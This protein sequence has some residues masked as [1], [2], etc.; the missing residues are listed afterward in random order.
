VIAVVYQAGEAVPEMQPA[1]R[2][3]SRKRR[4]QVSAMHLVVRRAEHGFEWLSER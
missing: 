2:H 3:P 4:Q 1:G